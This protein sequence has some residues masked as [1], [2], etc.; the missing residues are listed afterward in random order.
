MKCLINSISDSLL[1]RMGIADSWLD[2]HVTWKL[3]YGDCCTNVKHS[4]V[5][6]KTLTLAYC[7]QL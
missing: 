2:A 1:R 5:R 3:I 6:C 4:V 7:A